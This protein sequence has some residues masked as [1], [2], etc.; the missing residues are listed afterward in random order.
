MPADG[1]IRT[2]LRGG[3]EGSN[4]L[5]S[6]GESTADLKTLNIPPA[7]ECPYDSSAERRDGATS[8][9]CR[10]GNWAI[11]RGEGAGQGLRDG[12]RRLHPFEPE[13]IE[14]AVPEADKTL[15]V[16]AFVPCDQGDVIYFDRPYYLRPGRP[17]SCAA[18][19]RRTRS[20]KRC[21]PA[22]IGFRPTRPRSWRRKSICR[23][24][25]S[26]R[27]SIRQPRTRAVSPARSLSLPFMVN[28]TFD[29]TGAP[30][31]ETCGCALVIVDA[32]V[33][34]AEAAPAI[35][36]PR[37]VSSRSPGLC[38]SYSRPCCRHGEPRR[39]R[40]VW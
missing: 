26:S 38:M 40:L 25:V 19:N 2:S 13:E 32:A 24:R 30:V 21:R 6:S 5:S 15:D 20:R 33:T 7:P 35:S 23:V 12:R 17:V 36:R 8:E 16:E 18:I 3:T 27:G 34:T 29:M 10:C 9:L 39:A 28:D 14:K 37:R 22:P 31:P 4:P 1:A 11:G